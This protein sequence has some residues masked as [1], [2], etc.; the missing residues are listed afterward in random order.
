MVHSRMNENDQVCEICFHN[1]SC[2]DPDHLVCGGD[3]YKF[4]YADLKIK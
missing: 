3:D 4:L 1:F 2:I